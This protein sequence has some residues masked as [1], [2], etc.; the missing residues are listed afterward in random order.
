MLP[1]TEKM[2][3]MEKIIEKIVKEEMDKMVIIK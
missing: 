3:T 2:V 1:K